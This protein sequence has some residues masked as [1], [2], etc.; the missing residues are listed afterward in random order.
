MS[1]NLFAFRRRFPH[2]VPVPWNWRFWISAAK[3]IIRVKLGAAL[4]VTY[5][6]NHPEPVETVGATSYGLSYV[7]TAQLSLYGSVTSVTA[8]TSYVRRAGSAFSSSLESS[9]VSTRTS[10]GSRTTTVTSATRLRSSMPSRFWMAGLRS[11]E[12][13][14]ES[15]GVDSS[16][17]SR[18]RS[19]SRSH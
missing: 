4:E 16:T 5:I 18:S 17:R 8:Q 15:V 13:E 10:G 19:R 3:P 9:F 14:W 11:P 12:S 1:V 2:M 7:F 6:H